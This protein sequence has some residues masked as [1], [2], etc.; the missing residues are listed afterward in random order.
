MT[1]LHVIPFLWSG[2]GRVLVHVCTAQRQAGAQVH[3]ATSSTSRGCTDWPAYRRALRRAGVIHHRIDTFDRDPSVFW[4][5]VGA[6]RALCVRLRPDVVHA[7]AGVPAVVAALARQDL[8]WRLPVVAQ[9]YSWGPG[10]APWMN[11]MDL[12]GFRAADAVV[13]SA[14][15]YRTLLRTA[16]VAASRLHMVDLGVDLPPAGP[17]AARPVPPKAGALGFVG[18]IEPRKRQRE[19]VRLLAALSRHRP[20]ATLDLV[21]PIADAAYAAALHTDVRAL[22]LTGRVRIHG[23]V[24]DVWAALGRLDLFVSLSEDEGQGLAVLEAMAAGVPVAAR[25]V[26]G[27]EDFLADD[28][29]GLALPTAAT[30]AL[31]TRVHRLLGD[32]TRRARLAR[33]GVTLVR[34]RYA[35]P[36]TMEAL[37]RVYEHAQARAG[38]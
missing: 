31:A 14:R 30:S 1:I 34:R 21:G 20:D 33:R 26:A 5:S 10:R 23:E 32:A 27:I 6:V 29:T 13:C 7:H 3:I 12:W 37:G 24:E 11:A 36:R 2:A 15:A 18:R 19:L 25:P 38:S 28:R 35:W 4:S 16:G 9:M 22:G 17:V 8:P